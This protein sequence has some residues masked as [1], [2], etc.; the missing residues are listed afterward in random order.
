MLVASFVVGIAAFA[1]GAGLGISSVGRANMNTAN[2]AAKVVKAELENMQKTLNQIGAAFAAS[3][4]RWPPPRRTPPPTTQLIDDLK[5]KLDPAPTPARSSASTT[6]ASRTWSSITC[7]TTTTT[8][9][10]LRR[11]RAPHPQDRQRSGA[12]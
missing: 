5:I 1:L 12:G 11:G 3:Q 8:H 9:R 4:Q 2:R 10:A 7:S 6:T